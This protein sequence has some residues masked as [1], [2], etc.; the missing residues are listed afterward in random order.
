MLVDPVD[1]GVRL[2]FFLFGRNL[3]VM[4]KG[5]G[6]FQAK[7]QKAVEFFFFPVYISFDTGKN[8]IVMCFLVQVN[9]YFFL[10]SHCKGMFAIFKI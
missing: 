10:A 6:F 4:V 1:D 3:K 2:V 5:T 8:I 9:G 7:R